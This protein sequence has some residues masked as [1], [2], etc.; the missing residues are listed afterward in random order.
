MPNPIDVKG[1]RFGDG[2]PVV[3]VPVV[4]RDRD[5]V[6]AKIRELTE[7]K[8]PMIEWRADCLD[9]IGQPEELRGVLKEITPYV[10]DTVML[11][12]IR[13]K[14]Q[15]GSADLGEKTLLYLD[16]VVAKSGVFDF[17]DLELF[18]LERPEREIRR[19]QQM[20]TRVIVS[21]HDFRSTPDDTVLHLLMEQLAISGGDIA[22]LAVMPDSAEDVI[23][24]LK[25]A[26]DTRLTYPELP[27]VAIAMGELGVISRVAGETFGSCISFGADGEGSAPG[28][29]QFDTLASILDALH[30]SRGKACPGG[31]IFLIGFMG[32]GK[33]VVSEKLGSLL[34]LPEIDL[35]EEVVR[36]NGMSIDQMFDQYGEDYFRER[37][38]ETLRNVSEKKPAVI[39]CGG[40]CVLRGQNVS[41]LKQNGTVVL[42]TAEPQTILE[43][44]KDSD[45]RPIL[46]DHMNLK[47]I[48]DLMEK[49]KEAYEAACDLR[50]CTDGRTPEDIAQEIRERL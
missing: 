26:N 18:E 48:A 47:Y 12:T 19:L 38:T 40:G 11:F 14:N 46:N 6:A 24:L 4:E 16:E 35:D 29:L 42:L 45:V 41:I 13:S 27:I 8:V 5:A 23:R 37:E 3:C 32:V 7:K 15:G 49:R 28:Q 25:L 9:G 1:I 21:H 36:E 2:R 10:S 33:T 43:R 44:V 50:V 39:S 17:I 30:A 34:G 31:H 20:G 22:K